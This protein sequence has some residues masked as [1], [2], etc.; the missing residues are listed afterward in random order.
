MPCRTRTH[1]AAAAAAAA[2]AATR[3]RRQGKGPAPPDVP[4]PQ[5]LQVLRG[6]DRRHQLQGRQ[7]ARAVRAGARQD[8]AAPHLGHLRD[9]P[10]Q[11]AD[12]D[13]ARAAA[14]ADSVRRRSEAV[15]EV[16]LR[17]HVENLGQ[18]AA[19]SSRSPTATRAT[20]CCRASWRC[21]RP[22]GNKKQVERERVKFDAQGGRGAEGGR[23]AGRAA[24]QRRDRHRRKV[25]ETEALYGSVTTADI[26]DALAA[27]GLRDRSPQAA[28]SPSRSR[29]S[30][31]TTCR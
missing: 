18:A 23:G 19:R 22:T 6:Q 24:G 30:A 3:S 29:R 10:A 20:I 26:A 11:A 9:A 27:Q 31:S 25:G 28:A 14:R 8:S 12:G 15:M 7:A 1:R 21:W 17:E 2:A 4:P 16:I 13:Q 5:G